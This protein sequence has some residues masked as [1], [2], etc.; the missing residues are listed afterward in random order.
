M[1]G[2]FLSG[3]EK[4]IRRDDSNEFRDVERNDGGGDDIGI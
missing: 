4:M 2:D 3:N 1:V